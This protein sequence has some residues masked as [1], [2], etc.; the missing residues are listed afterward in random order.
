MPTL[1]RGEGK[2]QETKSYWNLPLPGT[3]MNQRENNIGL[4]HP[5]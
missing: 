3:K 2:K 4:C 5:S 1:V